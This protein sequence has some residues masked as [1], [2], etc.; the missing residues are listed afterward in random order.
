[1]DFGI[2]LIQSWRKYKNT[3]QKFMIYIS[4]YIIETNIDKEISLH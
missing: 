3:T 2:K 4:I 1:M